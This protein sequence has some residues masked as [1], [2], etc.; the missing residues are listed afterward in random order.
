MESKDLERRL[1]ALE[2]RNRSLLAVLGA[3]AALVCLGA[4]ARQDAVPDELRARRIVMV[5]A[6]GRARAEL[7][8]DEEGSAGLFVRDVEGRPRAIV[9][10]DESQSAL[11]LLD[12]KGTIRLGSAQYA[13]GGGG[14]ALHGPEAKGAAVLYLKDEGSLT[15]Y[16]EEGQ[17][18]E[19]IAP[20]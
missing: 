17:V 2:R 13:H 4:F 9:V 20:Q 16:G 7:G 12:E 18:L 14:Y 1:E 3:M 6:E 5:D 8:L 10:H 15:F 11:Y 19:R